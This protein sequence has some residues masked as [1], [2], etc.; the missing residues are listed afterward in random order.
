[1]R[2]KRVGRSGRSHLLSRSIVPAAFALSLIAPVT[3]AHATYLPLNACAP[4]LHG[5]YLNTVTTPQGGF[6]VLRSLATFTPAGA[7]SVVESAEGGLPNV[8]GPYSDAQG[9]WACIAVNG[10]TAHA[11]ATVFDFTYGGTQF[12]AR[13]DYD[14]TVNAA[15][16]TFDGTIEVRVYPLEGPPDPLNAPNTLPLATYNISGARVRVN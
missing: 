2:D 5:T 1:M 14:I 3:A 11:K 10:R 12:I 15:T 16:K 13:I 6:F 4:L 9:M 8:V 7:V